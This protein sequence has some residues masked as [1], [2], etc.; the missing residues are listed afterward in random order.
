VFGCWLGLYGMQGEAQRH[1]EISTAAA[2]KGPE[3]IGVLV[4][5]SAYDLTVGQPDLNLLHEVAAESEVT[6]SEPDA[7]AEQKG[8]GSNAG[9][10]AMWRG[11]PVPADFRPG[12]GKGPVHVAIQGAAGDLNDAIAEMAHPAHPAGMDDETGHDAAAGIAVA[13]GAQHHRDSGLTRPGDG[14][15]GFGGVA[16]PGDPER[17]DAIVT[18]ILRPGEFG[19]PAVAW[20][21]YAASHVG[22]QALPRGCRNRGWLG[23]ADGGCKEGRGGRG[24]SELH[25]TSTWKIH[26][27]SCGCR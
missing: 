2:T 20:L 27:A 26:G 4:L 24:S 8:A 16:R 6:H 21:Q 19:E 23:V 12:A 11:Q 25:K 13:A 9:A 17:S 7:A 5:R 18:E 1:A 3:Q 14:G 10:A 15:E 22:C